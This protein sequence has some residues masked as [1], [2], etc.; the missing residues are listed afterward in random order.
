[1]K[2]SM[3]L[4]GLFLAIVV[5][6]PGCMHVSTYQ[7]K[8]LKAVSDQCTYRGAEKNVIVQAKLLSREDK[9]FL[10]GP[11]HE[12]LDDKANNSIQVI[13]FSIH[14]LSDNF[15][16]FS[17]NDIDLV[18]IPHQKIAQLMKTSTIGRY[19]ASDG[20]VLL[21]G[22]SAA[23]ASLGF[24][25]CGLAFDNG[26]SVPRWWWLAPISFV[27]TG[28]A[29]I[30]SAIKLQRSAKKSEVMN[31]RIR[32]DLAVKGS[33]KSL[34]I[35]SGEQ[36]AGLVFVKSSDY[37]PQFAITMHEKGNARNSITFDVDLR[38]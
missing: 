28:V 4:L 21:T 2:N 35:S 29:S 24:L 6:L 23:G 31:N 16:F 26:E 3:R 12:N 22:A 27:V 32:E 13:Y 14:N 30:V 9:A 20:F 25:I 38:E 17:A 36:Y 7:R 34:I 10:F 37:T 33:Q 8:A 15:Y 18:A 5:L 11:R 19:M 1:M